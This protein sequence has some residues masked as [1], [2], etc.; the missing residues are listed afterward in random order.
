MSPIRITSV[1]IHHMEGRLSERFGWSL[2][3]TW[4]RT[5]DLIEVTTDAGLTGW[6]EGAW[7]GDLLRRNPEL[8]I[9]R[10]P[11]ELAGIYDSLRAPTANQRRTGPPLGSGLDIALWDLAGRA[12]DTPV[13]RLLGRVYRDRV[14]AYCTALYRKDWPD[15]AEGLSQ[16]AIEWKARGY[17]AI[18]MKIGYDPVT[19]LRIVR[20]VRDTVGDELL[21]GVDSNCAYDSSTAIALAR[22]LEPFN[23]MWWEEPLLADDLDGYDRLARATSIPIAAGESENADWLATH[24][25]I[26]QRVAILQPDLEWVGLTGFRELN[27]FCWLRHMRL[28]PHNWGTALRTAATLHAMATCPPLTEALTPPRILFEFDRAEHPFRDAIL[29]QRL[30]IDSEAQVAVPLGPGLGVDVDTDAVARFRTGLTVIESI[31]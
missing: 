5:V 13:C 30:D 11:F 18:K 31:R 4:R 10:S 25:V 3:W 1:R 23:L 12:L 9:G 17:R 14:E 16:E 8:V 2:N 24:Y 28:V 29:R 22:Q 20:A 26:P 27:R 15:L 6:G 7:G 19:D 21:L